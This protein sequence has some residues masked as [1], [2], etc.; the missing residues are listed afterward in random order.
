MTDKEAV[1]R[2]LRVHGSIEPLTALREIG[3]FRLGARIWDLRQAFAREYLGV[4]RLPRGLSAELRHFV[5]APMY[6]S[7]SSLRRILDGYRRWPNLS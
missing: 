3:T 5:K 2:W 6:A 4:A 1:L 7:H